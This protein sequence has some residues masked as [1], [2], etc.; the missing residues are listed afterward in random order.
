MNI[1]K[2][3]K[4]MTLLIAWKNGNIELIKYLLN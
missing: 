4:N 1:N 2:K 3:N